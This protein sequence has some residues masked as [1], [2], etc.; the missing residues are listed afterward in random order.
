MDSG[1]SS[2]YADL[3]RGHWWW[4]SREHLVVTRIAERAPVDGWERALDV[5]CGDAL[6]LGKLAR[7]ANTVEGLEIDESLVSKGAAER[8]T[9]HF[10]ALA[11]T[12]EPATPYDFVSMLDVLEHIEEPLPALKRA[13]EV[14]SPGGVLLITVPAFQALWTSHDALNHHFVQ[15]TRRGLARLVEEAGFDVVESRYFFHWLALPKWLLGRIERAFGIPLHRAEIPRR[16]FNVL[17]HAVSRIEQA[18]FKP[19]GWFPGSSVL[20][21]ALARPSDS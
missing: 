2:R 9:I 18:A 10:G 6:F 15:Y 1:Y 7:F 21:V 17:L 8:H 13:R 3:Y 16:A 14:L 5:G 11:E 19:L 4:R 12:F 20:L